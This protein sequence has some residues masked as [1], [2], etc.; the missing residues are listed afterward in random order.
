MGQVYLLG[1]RTKWASYPYPFLRRPSFALNIPQ[2]SQSLRQIATLLEPIT[3]KPFIR[4]RSAHFIGG[5]ENWGR[6]SFFF[7]LF[8]G[9]FLKMFQGKGWPRGGEILRVMIADAR[10]PLEVKNVIIKGCGGDRT[11]LPSCV[12]RFISQDLQ[13]A[14]IF[15]LRFNFN[16]F[17]EE[18]IN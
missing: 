4:W 17:I 6:V 5:G 15:H 12:H 13:I 10:D 3:F 11:G 2:H 14:L 9:W 16:T 7:F 8:E 18:I 1:G